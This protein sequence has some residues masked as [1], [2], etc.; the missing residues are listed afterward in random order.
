VTA[1]HRQHLI[2]EAARIMAE[3]D[4]KDFQIAKRKAAERLNLPVG[5]FLPANEEVETALR[6]YLALF[7]G[8]AHQHRIQHLRQMAVEAMHFLQQFEPRLVG[9]VL[10]GTATP[11]TAVQLHVSAETPEEVALLLYERHIPF[12]QA[13]RRVRFGGERVA[14]V[15]AFRFVVSAATGE[16]GTTQDTVIELWVFNMRAVRELP[17]SPVDGKPMQRADVRDVERL[18]QAG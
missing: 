16:T 5:K 10:S 17:L 11:S 9:A 4:I 12:D 2:A 3:E 18:L 13:E 8:T 15:P 1:Q 7:G 14:S 6:E